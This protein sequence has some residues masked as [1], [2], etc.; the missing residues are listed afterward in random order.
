MCVA[1]PACPRVAQVVRLCADT[2]PLQVTDLKRTQTQ[3]RPLSLLAYNA[4]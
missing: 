3:I 2:R 4:L 1:L